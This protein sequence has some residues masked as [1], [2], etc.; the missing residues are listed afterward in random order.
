[1]NSLEAL[2]RGECYDDLTLALDG[3]AK[4]ECGVMDDV[5]TRIEHVETH[6]GFDYNH[7]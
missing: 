4:D 2:A 6:Q 1:V 5:M 7:D 3:V